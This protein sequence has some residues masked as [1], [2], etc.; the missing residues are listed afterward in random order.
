MNTNDLSMNETQ[1]RIL[2]QI[3]KG[4]RKE[5]DKLI[6]DQIARRESREESVRRLNRDMAAGR[7]SEPLPASPVWDP[8]SVWE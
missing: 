5:V 4:G 1:M 8:A 7:G 3:A 6:A 2:R